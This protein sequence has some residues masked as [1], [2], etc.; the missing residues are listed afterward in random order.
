MAAQSKARSGSV[1]YAEAEYTLWE[2][3]W[4]KYERKKAVEKAQPPVPDAVLALD[5]WRTGAPSGCSSGTC[6]LSLRASRAT[7][8]FCWT[9]MGAFF[10]LPPFRSGGGSL[11]ADGP[12]SRRGPF[13]GGALFEDGRFSRTGLG[14]GLGAKHSSLTI[15]LRSFACPTSAAGSCP[16]GPHIAKRSS[17]TRASPTMRMIPG[18]RSLRP[19][20]CCTTSRRRTY[21]VVVVKTSKRGVV[22]VAAYGIVGLGGFDLIRRPTPPWRPRPARCNASSSVACS[23]RCNRGSRCPRSVHPP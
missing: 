15:A 21:V 3:H 10:G 11:F 12:F 5:P 7:A 18:S 23:G 8:N 4:I 17:R 6:S 14:C 13:R 9:G 2:E 16:T 1:P 20:R 22:V 19:L